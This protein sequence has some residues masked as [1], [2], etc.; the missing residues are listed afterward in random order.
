MWTD[1]YPYRCIFGPFIICNKLQFLTCEGAII[2]D[3]TDFFFLDSFAL[4]LEFKEY[5]DWP[6][7]NTIIKG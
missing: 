6:D 4:T 5:T 3:T 7:G 2:K 1:S